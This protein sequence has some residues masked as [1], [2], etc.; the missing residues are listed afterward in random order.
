MGF[1]GKAARVIYNTFS[2][3]RTTIRFDRATYSRIFKSTT[4]VWQGSSPSIVLVTLVL[5]PFVQ[6]L[7][8]TFK[9]TDES[10]RLADETPLHCLCFCDD[11]VL[12]AGSMRE[13][14]AKIIKI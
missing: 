7:R 6:E 12:L 2:H 11:F 9:G 3:T 8:D 1:E 10:T 13:L 4:G 5:E 14:R